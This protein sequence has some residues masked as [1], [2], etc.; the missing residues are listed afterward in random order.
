LFVKQRQIERR[1]VIGCCVVVVIALASCGSNSTGNEGRRS[2][3]S[4]IANNTTTPS[5]VPATMALVVEPPKLH[6]GD[7]VHLEG[8]GCFDPTTRVPGALLQLPFAGPHPVVAADGTFSIEATVPGNHPPG[9]TAVSAA[10]F[11]ANAT[12]PM[13][14]SPPVPVSVETPYQATFSPT[15]IAPGG[16]VMFQGDCPGSAGY[17]WM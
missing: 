3:T 12:R 16:T 14:V 1:R 7:T 10:C 13:V 6:N 8:T 11:S 5:E 2:A 9:D 4:T 15:R 17:Q